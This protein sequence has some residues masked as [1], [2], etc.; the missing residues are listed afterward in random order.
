MNIT[1]VL[2]WLVLA[3]YSL[4]Q[5]A[6]ADVSADAVWI[7]VRSPAET[8]SGHLPQ[9]E[10]IPFDG[11]EVGVAELQLNKH[12]PIYLYCASGGRAENAKG[13]LEAIGF[14][15]VTNVGGLDDAQKL[16][17]ASPGE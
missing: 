9:A 5:P 17:G 11:I 6:W 10:L 16:I 13:R 1:A 4:T 3:V 7:D 12:T 15:E 2:L 8:A 14:T